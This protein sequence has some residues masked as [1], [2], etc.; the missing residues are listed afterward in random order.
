MI[1]SDVGGNSLGS[2][3]GVKSKELA[4]DLEHL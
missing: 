2:L 4:K 3:P 1:G